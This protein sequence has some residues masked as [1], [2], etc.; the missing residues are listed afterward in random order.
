MFIVTDEERVRGLNVRSDSC[1]KMCSE[2]YMQLVS[3]PS[4]SPNSSAEE[5]LTK[6]GIDLYQILRLFEKKS[7]VISI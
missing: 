4:Y 7:P 5:H 1:F 2:E 3:I 6:F